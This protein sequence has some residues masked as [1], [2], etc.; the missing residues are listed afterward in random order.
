MHACFIG[1]QKLYRRSG[2]QRQQYDLCDISATYK[3]VKPRDKVS[4]EK[5]RDREY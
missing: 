4:R 2:T 3:L 1:K 5:K